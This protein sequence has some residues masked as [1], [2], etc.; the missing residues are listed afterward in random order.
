M[1]TLIV[2]SHNS[3]KIRE[4]SHV[5]S[6]TG[7]V[8]KGL[9]DLNGFKMPAETGSTFLENAWL[10]AEA[11]HEYLR[12]FMKHDPN[13]SAVYVLADDSGLVCDDLNGQ[14]GIYSARFAGEHATDE[15]NNEKLLQ[16]LKKKNAP[17]LKGAYVCALALIL[18]NQQKKEFMASC[19]GEISFDAKGKYGFGYDPYFYVPSL[20]KHMAE[21]DPEV[22]NQISHRGKAL[23]QLLDFLDA[24]SNLS[25]K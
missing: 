16:E 10:K 24:E 4:I 7:F 22:K 5:L 13:F 12:H 11:V 9:S 25:V 2:A 17:T 19:S 6:G 18:P 23:Q 21:L 20:N 1:K 15:Q 8:V 14:P 3:H